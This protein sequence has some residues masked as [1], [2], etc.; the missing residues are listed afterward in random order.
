MPYIWQ[1][2][3]W[4]DFSWQDDRL[5]HAIGQARLAQGKLLS[6]VQAL[7]IELSREAQAEILTEETIKTAAIEGE[8][9]DKNSVRSSVA[10]RLGLPIA[11][12]PHTARH[13]DGLV[14]VL[15]DA[16]AHYDKP[17]TAERLKGW[18]AA[19]FPTGFSGLHRI[20]VGKW[21]GPEP[22]QV[23]SGPLGQEKVH[24]EAPPFE[25][26]EEEMERFFTWWQ[27]SQ[28]NIEGLLRAGIAH[29][30]F[31]TIHP[32]EDGNGRIARALTDMALA[33][34]EH[35]GKRFYSLSSR[36]MAEREDYYNILEQTQKGNG[37]ITGWLL[38]F[39]GC[40]QR[41]IE[42]S[43]RLI[44]GVMIKANFWQKHAQIP[45]TQNQRK[46]INRML[47]AEPKG[48]AG[49]LTT[50]KYVS[51]AKVSRATA[52]REISHLVKKG[53]LAPNPGKGRNISYHLVLND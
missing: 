17:L 22:M 50:R 8:N 31:V 33:R 30:R 18:Q 1:H 13:I 24:F 3:R 42:D 10:R 44:A 5:I 2:D 45:L 34:D 43:Q 20:R 14:E 51:I 7:G 27:E 19:L 26:I 47:D 12:L 32:F 41:A 11:G 40:M 6:K 36:I 38:W 9:L 29:F 46:V 4:P 28:G 39:L 15:L 52:Y 23:V 16:T 21:R 48:F 35:M 49:G 37:D 25:R 53:I